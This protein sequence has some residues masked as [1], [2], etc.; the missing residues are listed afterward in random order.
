MPQPSK[1][2]LHEHPLLYTVTRLIENAE[3]MDRL[4]ERVKLKF[5][6]LRFLC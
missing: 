6:E 5:S 4:N 1:I 2:V 3:M